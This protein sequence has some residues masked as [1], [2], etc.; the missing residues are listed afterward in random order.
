MS[1]VVEVIRPLIFRP[2]LGRVGSV[3]FRYWSVDVL[4]SC[5][6]VYCSAIYRHLTNPFN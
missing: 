2:M 6:F 5:R 1:L 4:L 3:V